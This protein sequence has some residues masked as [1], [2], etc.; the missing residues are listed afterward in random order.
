L[1]A[2][3]IQLRAEDG[4]VLKMNKSYLSF[5]ILGCGLV[6]NIHAEALKS[7][8]GAHFSCVT[9]TNLSKAR[10]FASKHGVRCHDSFEDM[11]NDSE[12]D[13]VLEPTAPIFPIAFPSP[14]NAHNMLQTPWNVLP[15][16]KYQT[17]LIAFATIPTI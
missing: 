5:G 14:G 7:L 9:D 16:E 10:D 12:I 4:T 13:A 2:T 11:L 8:D 6:A 15:S 1:K 3:T 17:A